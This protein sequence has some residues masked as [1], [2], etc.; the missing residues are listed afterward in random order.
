MSDSGKPPKRRYM[1]FEPD[2]V[3]IAEVQFIDAEPDDRFFK[4]RL[5]GPVLDE[6]YDGCALVAL[7]HALPDGVTEGS[8]CLIKLN[9]MGPMRAEV[10]WIRA[11]DDDV[12]KIGVHY[13]DPR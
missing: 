7:R 11:L 6:S 13:G 2:E 1:R 8:L 4:P 3:V 10:R 12:C 9:R 5:A